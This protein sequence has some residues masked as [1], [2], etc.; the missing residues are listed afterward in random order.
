MRMAVF[1]FFREEN[2][3]SARLYDLDEIAEQEIGRDRAKQQVA[4][5][6]HSFIHS[7]L[8]SQL[9]DCVGPTGPLL[10]PLM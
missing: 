2:Q 8:S 10:R 7:I 3:S 6:F 5:S 4:H 9:V 1:L